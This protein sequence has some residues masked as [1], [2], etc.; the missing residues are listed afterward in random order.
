M[1]IVCS[2]QPS[3]Q[4][5][6]S[7]TNAIRRRKVKILAE[8]FPALCAT[9]DV[10]PCESQVG[11]QSSPTHAAKMNLRTI[12]IESS[13]NSSALVKST[14]SS[15][16]CL[17]QDC[18]D[19]VIRYHGMQPMRRRRPKCLFCIGKCQVQRPMQTQDIS[20]VE[21]R[22]VQQWDKVATADDCY[23]S[24]INR[25]MMHT[26]QRGVLLRRIGGLKKSGPWY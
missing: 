19:V 24:Y 11:A 16:P 20:I 6:K 12:A 2:Q 9:K 10:A 23:I 5:A 14:Q 15:I 8:F 4:I 17:E 1:F 13:L 21:E 3:L 18:V 26:T 22:S 7:F 25:N